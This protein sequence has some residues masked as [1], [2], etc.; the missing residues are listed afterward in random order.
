LREAKEKL[1]I[2][3]KKEQALSDV[4]ADGARSLKLLKLRTVTVIPVSA[5]AGRMLWLYRMVA[6]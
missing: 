3:F 5:C 6:A 1:L 2:T 4:I